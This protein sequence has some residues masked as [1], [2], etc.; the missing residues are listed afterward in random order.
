MTMIRTDLSRR[1][2]LDV[3]AAG[4]VDIRERGHMQPGDG[5]RLPVFSTDTREQAL[6]LQ[7]RH[8]RLAQ[9]NSGLYFLNEPPTD[10]EDLGRVSALFRATYAEED[11]AGKKAR[12]ALS[13][14]KVRRIARAILDRAAA[15]DDGS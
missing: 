9:D 7:V 15:E 13:D 3:C 10:V 2:F 5:G 12:R 14:P 6:S 4:S 11:A 8:C 1:F